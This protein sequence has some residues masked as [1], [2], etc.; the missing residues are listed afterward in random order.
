MVAVCGCFVYTPL[1]GPDFSPGKRVDVWAQM[2]TFTEGSALAVAVEIIVTTF[3]QRAPGMT[4]DRIPLF[5]WSMRVTSFL[6]ILAMP[7]VMVASITMILDPLVPTHFFI[8]AAAGD[9]LLWH[10]LFWFFGHP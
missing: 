4:L 10:R 9:A 1:S 2:I 7:S 8:H 5:V 3:K 6:I